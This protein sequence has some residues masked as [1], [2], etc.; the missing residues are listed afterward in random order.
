MKLLTF[1]KIVL[2]LKDIT[3]MGK[4]GW[5]YSGIPLPKAIFIR[6]KNQEVFFD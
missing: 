3:D 5:F 6:T 4:L 2:P 1:Q